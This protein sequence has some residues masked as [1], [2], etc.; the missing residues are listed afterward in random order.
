MSV[1]KN[2]PVPPPGST[3]INNMKIRQLPN[4]TQPLTIV[5]MDAAHGAQTPSRNRRF[6]RLIGAG[7]RRT[8]GCALSPARLCLYNGQM[9]RGRH[10]CD[11]RQ[12]RVHM[13]KFE[14]VAKAPVRIQQNILARSERRLLNWRCARL[15][16][17]VT[18]DQLT[19]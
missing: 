11:S 12:Q 17:W 8:D 18:P 4:I 3:H 5:R 1:V 2:L 10:F 6:A 15:P 19:T 9:T 14:P 7:A 16:A 13:S